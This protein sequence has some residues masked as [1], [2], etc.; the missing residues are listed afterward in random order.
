MMPEPTKQKLANLKTA[1]VRASG[2]KEYWAQGL[3]VLGVYETKDGTLRFQP[4]GTKKEPEQD[5]KAEKEAGVEEEQ[6]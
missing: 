3:R 2:G 4:P 6:V 1:T 5:S